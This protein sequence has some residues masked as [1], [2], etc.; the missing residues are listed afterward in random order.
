MGSERFYVVFNCLFVSFSLKYMK[1]STENVVVLLSEY[2]YLLINSYNRDCI[3][4]IYI[5]FTNRKIKDKYRCATCT[6]INQMIITHQTI[7][8]V[9][10][11]TTDC[12]KK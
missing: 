8:S 1:C 3:V 6:T 4:P 7:H 5:I 10:F 2:I 12:A 9:T 11:L